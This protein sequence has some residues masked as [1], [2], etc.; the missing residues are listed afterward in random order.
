MISYEREVA[1]DV[2]SASPYSADPSRARR[3]LIA[4]AEFGEVGDEQ[5]GVMVA[6]TPEGFEVTPWPGGRS[7]VTKRQA[8]QLRDKAMEMA[9]DLAAASAHAENLSRRA[10]EVAAS[11]HAGTEDTT[12]IARLAADLEREYSAVH[13]ISNIV[14][15]GARILLEQGEQAR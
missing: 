10:G 9:G 15:D 1:V 2:L 14:L 12:A 4:A 6:K 8:A 7:R 3:L 11:G 5:H 13:A